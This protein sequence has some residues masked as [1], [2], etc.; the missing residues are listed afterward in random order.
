MIYTTEKRRE[1]YKRKKFPGFLKHYKDSLVYLE[2]RSQ[3]DM[4]PE[5]QVFLSCF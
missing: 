1:V 5:F 2:F 3:K 4:A